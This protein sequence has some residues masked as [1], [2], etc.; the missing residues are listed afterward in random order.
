MMTA[1]SAA[2]LCICHVL[3]TSWGLAQLHVFKKWNM[4]ALLVLARMGVDFPLYMHRLEAD[5]SSLFYLHM[6]KGDED[7]DTS[8]LRHQISLFLRPFTDRLRT[9]L[10]LEKMHNLDS[11]QREKGWEGRAVTLTERA[12]D[13]HMMVNSSLVDNEFSGANLPCRLDFSLTRKQFLRTGLSISNFLASKNPTE[14]A[15]RW[16]VSFLARFGSHWLINTTM[17][18]LLNNTVTCEDLPSRL[19]AFIAFNVTHDVHVESREGHSVSRQVS[20]LSPLHIM[21]SNL[22]E[23]WTATL[24]VTKMNALPYKMRGIINNTEMNFENHIVQIRNSI[25][26]WH[27]DSLNE[28]RETGKKAVLNMKPHQI[29]YFSKLLEEKSHDMIPLPENHIFYP[30]QRISNQRLS[31]FLWQ[32]GYDTDPLNEDNYA[33]EEYSTILPGA[34]PVLKESMRL[35]FNCDNRTSNHCAVLQASVHVDNWIALQ[36]SKVSL[37]DPYNSDG[38]RNDDEQVFKSQ[39]TIELCRLQLELATLGI[40][41]CTSRRIKFLGCVMESVRSNLGHWLHNRLRDSNSKNNDPSLIDWN[42]PIAVET[43]TFFCSDQLNNA[44]REVNRSKGGSEHDSTDHTSLHMRILWEIQLAL[45]ASKKRDPGSVCLMMLCMLGYPS[46]RVSQLHKRFKTFS[47]ESLVTSDAG[48]TM[49]GNATVVHIEPSLPASVIGEHKN[50]KPEHVCYVVE[51]ADA[52]QPLHILF[53]WSY[54]SKRAEIQICCN[55]GYRVNQFCW[56]SWKDG[57]MGRM[58]AQSEWRKKRLRVGNEKIRKEAVSSKLSDGIVGAYDSTATLAYWRGWPPFRVEIAGFEVQVVGCEYQPLSNLERNLNFLEGVQ[59]EANST[60]QEIEATNNDIF[61]NIECGCGCV[62]H[63]MYLRARALLADS[64]ENLAFELFRRCIEDHGHV[65]A[66]FDYIRA[67]LAHLP[68]EEDV[69]DQLLSVMCTGMERIH[70]GH[71]FTACRKFSRYNVEKLE[72]LFGQLYEASGYAPALYYGALALLLRSQSEN[73]VFE[74]C[75]EAF[76]S[77]LLLGDSDSSLALASHFALALCSFLIYFSSKKDCHRKLGTLHLMNVCEERFFFQNFAV[78]IALFLEKGRISRRDYGRIPAIRQK[79]PRL[80]ETLLEHVFVSSNGR[81][82]DIIQDKNAALSIYISILNKEGLLSKLMNSRVQNRLGLM[83]HKTFKDVEKAMAF[84]TKAIEFERFPPGTA[85]RL[86]AMCNLAVLYGEQDRNGEYA[87]YSAE[88]FEHVCEEAMRANKD[89]RN[90]VARG[91]A[92]PNP[93]DMHSTSMNNLAVLTEYGEI[94]P[95]N[96]KKAKE[97]YL[98]SVEI[99]E[100]PIAAYNLALF[101]K[102]HDPTPENL[103]Q[104]EHLL[105]SVASLGPDLNTLPNLHDQLRKT[106]DIPLGEISPSLL[107]AVEELDD[108]LSYIK[109][110]DSVS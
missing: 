4:H 84:Y 11:V 29:A 66:L 88:L 12:V 16:S 63:E 47:S 2:L 39:K 109:T 28:L 65:H 69:L 49:E 38:S 83:H 92:T 105:S 32:L 95:R 3:R 52:P 23:P 86:N 60:S 45:M 68:V 67:V 41:A 101:L 76:E 44:L 42:P 104:A 78:G 35:C 71:T 51:I 26:A 57:F 53:K 87:M 80:L 48:D 97:L 46:L 94:V 61:S 50:C 64:K 99:D 59:A 22:Q 33:S 20:V 56:Q 91:N 82:Q 96:L 110:V 43:H 6:S 75:I 1:I 55:E 36:A 25:S 13:N 5:W 70:D 58:C 77:Y 98:R 74:R 15:V 34:F 72:E 18:Q 9:V 81:T 79:F 17:P 73:E 30:F 100:N 54:S 90:E 24:R 102:L 103:E 19:A 31:T 93:L 14:C 106:R 89:R 27:K 7:R 108:C 8:S 85:C 21:C 62:A 37:S 10:G 40:K 107:F